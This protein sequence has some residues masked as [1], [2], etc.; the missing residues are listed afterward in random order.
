[1]LQNLV[2]KAAAVRDQISL[3]RDRPFHDGRTAAG[4]VDAVK[5]LG[6]AL[7]DLAD[8]SMA[9]DMT[10]ASTPGHPHEKAGPEA[11]ES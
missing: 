1:M 11:R 4:I 10:P 2:V 6:A 7:S 8:R 3:A 5:D 9:N